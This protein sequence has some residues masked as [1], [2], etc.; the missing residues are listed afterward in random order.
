M[1]IFVGK[2]QL[3][4]DAIRTAI[5]PIWQDAIIYRAVLLTSQ[6]PASDAQQRALKIVAQFHPDF[7]GNA[8]Y[9]KMPA[10]KLCKDLAETIV[11]N[12]GYASADAAI[13]AL[14]P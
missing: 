13:Q 10:R 5:P 4:L 9:L 8:G 6:A 3:A 11:R 7:R 2:L 1:G 12:L 14:F